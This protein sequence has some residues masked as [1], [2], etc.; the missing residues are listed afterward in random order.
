MPNKTNKDIRKND[1]YNNQSQLKNYKLRQ[2]SV[3][4]ESIFSSMEDPINSNR[5]IKVRQ[6]N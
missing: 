2:Q 1:Q 5:V 4:N 3:N 6:E